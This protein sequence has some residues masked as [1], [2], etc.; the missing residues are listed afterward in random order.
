MTEILHIAEKGHWE[1][2][3]NKGTYTVESLTSQGFIHCSFPD[4]VGNIANALF[5]GRK[6]L[7]LLHIDPSLVTAE[8][9]Y[10]QPIAPSNISSPKEVSGPN[11]Q[12]YPHIYGP[13]NLNAVISATDFIPNENGLF[14][15]DLT[16]KH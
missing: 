16:S 4:Q 12:K 9:K 1:E 6:D 13:L 15:P 14:Q 10:E 11:T 5:K 7:V 3:K 8:I 2:A